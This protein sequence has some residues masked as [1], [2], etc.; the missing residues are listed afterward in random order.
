MK[1]TL[2]PKSKPVEPMM[3]PAPM[4]P[5]PLQ[6][7][8]DE[9]LVRNGLFY[10]DKGFDNDSC[11]PIC[12]GITALNMLPEEKRP[13]SI[14]IIINS[15]G[16]A[17][18]ACQQ[19]LHTMAASDITVETHAVGLAASCGVLTFM[20]GHKGHRYA[21]EGAMIMSHVYSA[22][23]MGKEGELVARRKANDQ[24]SDWMVE[25][26]K[27]HTKKSKAYIR[28]HL[29]HPIDEWMSPEE[30]VEHGIADHVVKAK[31]K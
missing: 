20:A 2:I 5:Q 12:K 24:L 17:V 6:M 1:K 15:P 4:P 7:Q 19:L 28:K 14:K 31:V 10:L 11:T 27:R 26:Y 25:H 29:L 22:G 21:Y 13:E 3:I 30:A 9:S 8:L 16:G 18:A 23:M